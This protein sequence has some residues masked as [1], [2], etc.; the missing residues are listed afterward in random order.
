M[1]YPNPPGIGVRMGNAAKMLYHWT[2]F[3]K[4]VPGFR[5]VVG[6]T[7]KARKRKKGYTI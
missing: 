1:T 4:R 5:P 3:R 7:L 6:D 2:F